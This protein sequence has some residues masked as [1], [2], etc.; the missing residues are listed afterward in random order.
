MLGIRGNENINQLDISSGVAVRAKPQ[1]V[2]FRDIGIFSV[3][4]AVACVTRPT[5]DNHSGC[6]ITT[7]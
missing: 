5:K 4:G 1:Q 2:I 3:A 7:R 6:F